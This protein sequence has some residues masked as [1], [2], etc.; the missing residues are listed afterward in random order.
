MERMARAPQE[1]RP[2]LVYVVPHLSE[3]ESEHF[4]HIPALLAALGERIDVAAVVERGT[5]P[6]RLPGVRLLLPV[7]GRGRLGRALGTALT[8]HRCARAGYRTYFLRYST[9]FVIILILTRPLYR[10][11][12][13]LWR[14]GLPD[15]RE[16]E[17]R[18]TLGDRAHDVVNRVTA[19]LVHCLVTGPE[20]MVPLMAGLWGVPRHRMRLLYNDVDAKRFAPLD[21]GERARARAR[22]GW[23][24]AE[25]VLLFVHRLSYRKG[26]RLLAPL[27]A[28]VSSAVEDQVD[29]SAAESASGVR[30][31]LVVAGDGPERARLVRQAADPALGGRMSLLGAVPNR[32]LPE[33]YAAA[34]CVVMPSYE[35]GFPRVLLEAMASAT[36][37]VTTDAGGSADV[38][39]A[40]YPYVAPVGDLDVLVG[41]VCA[42]VSAAPAERRA[43]GRRLRAR[44]ECEFSPQRVAAML[45]DLL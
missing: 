39:G 20:T 1:A 27:L 2:R 41:H 18:K 45:H 16:P 37:V 15:V 8:I 31:R 38:V 28:A 13:L 44:A 21:E 9:L 19:R 17:Q 5:P 35:E 25:F 36:P 4:A 11:R 24:E 42:V 43:L 30:V 40:G 14:S 6:A 12:I 7:P 10:H 3:T 34:D 26:V 32:D 23:G 22:L 29:A 33:L